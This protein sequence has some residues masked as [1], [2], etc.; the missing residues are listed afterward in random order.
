LEI[1]QR[2]L[3]NEPWKLEIHQRMNLL[4]LENPLP[5]DIW[6]VGLRAKREKKNLQVGGGNWLEIHF[7]TNPTNLANEIRTNPDER[8]LEIGN[9]SNEP[10]FVSVPPPPPY[11]SIFTSK[12][13]KGFFSILASEPRE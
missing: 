7:R 4:E 2:N 6:R 11:S 1:H 3:A 5:N 9:L 13:Q 8:T 10:G 12:T